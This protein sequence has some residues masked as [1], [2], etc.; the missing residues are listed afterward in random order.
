[1]LLENETTIRPPATHTM[2]SQN[3]RRFLLMIVKYAW[4][5]KNSLILLLV[6]SVESHF[7]NIISILASIDIPNYA[8]Y[9]YHLNSGDHH[10]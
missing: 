7:E 3:W 9:S 8:Y 10:K 5:G 4:Y 2:Q 1:M 6:H